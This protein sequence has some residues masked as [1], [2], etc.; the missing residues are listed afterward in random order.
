MNKIVNNYLKKNVGYT[1][2]IEVRES[3]IARGPRLIDTENTAVTTS[4]YNI[5]TQV[6]VYWDIQAC[7]YITI[8]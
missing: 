4:L 6:T 5:I 8:Y 2:K 1:F 7:Y 3:L